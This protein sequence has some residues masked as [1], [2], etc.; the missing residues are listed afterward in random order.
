MIVSCMK[1]RSVPKLVIQHQQKRGKDFFTEAKVNG[2]AVNLN[3]Q[4]IKNSI[5]Y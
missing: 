2:S 3:N 4:Q 1:S 5:R